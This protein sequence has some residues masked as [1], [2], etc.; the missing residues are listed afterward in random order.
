MVPLLLFSSHTAP[1][2][3]APQPRSGHSM[4]SR[5]WGRSIPLFLPYDRGKGAGVPPPLLN[6]MLFHCLGLRIILSLPPQTVQQEQFNHYPAGCTIGTERKTVCGLTSAFL[7][8]AVWSR[9]LQST[10]TPCLLCPVLL[11]STDTFTNWRRFRQP[12]V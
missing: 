3:T 1:H 11:R 5:L 4:R 10:S 12:W 9:I 2:Q 7:W 6:P 8:M